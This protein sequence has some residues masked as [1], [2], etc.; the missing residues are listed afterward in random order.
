MKTENRPL[1]DVTAKFEFASW[2]FKFEKTVVQRRKLLQALTLI[3]IKENYRNSTL[4]RL[5]LLKKS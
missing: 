1:D 5:I 3:K 4:K 2:E